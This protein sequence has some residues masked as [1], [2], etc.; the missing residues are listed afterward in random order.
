MSSSTNQHIPT[1]SSDLP[2]QHTTTAPHLDPNA[3][4]TNNGYAPNDNQL[5]GLVEAATAAADQ[6][7][8]QWAAAAAVAA[9][10]GAAGHHHQLDSYTDMDLSGN[11]FGDA[12]FGTG[13]SSGRHMRAPSH[14]D[15]P[16]SSGLTRTATKKR[17]RNEDHD[18]LDPALAGEG[19][20]DTQH[21]SHPAQQAP[22][23]YTGEEHQSHPAQQAPN[24]YTGE[25]IDIRPEQQQSLS[26][27]RAVG[28]HSAAALFRQPSSNKKYT[29]PPISK[30]YASLG[31]SPENF[32]HLQSAAKH[33]MLDEEHPERQDCVGQRGR[34]DSEMVKLRLWNCV[35]QFLDAEG[36]GARFFGEDAVNDG[37]GT[38]IHTWPRDQ[39]KIISLITPLLRRMV[40]NERQRRYAIETRKGGG[41]EA[42][43]RRKTEELSA[44]S[45]EFSP[46]QQHLQMQNQPSHRDDLSQSMA[47]PPPMQQSAMDSSQPVDLGLTDLL[48][49]GYT[50]DWEE[51]AR[52]Y[53]TYNENFE[54]DN[55]WSLSGLQQ[56]D[57]RG[58]VAA[59]DSHYHVVHN[60]NYDCPSIC[61]DANINRIVHADTTSDLQWRIGGGRN[62][63]A[64]V[65]FASSITRDV[66]RIIRE[67][68]AARHGLPAEA[69]DPHFH[70]PFTPLPE[71]TP[72]NTSNS[73][74]GQSQTSIRVNILQNGKRILPGFELPASQCSNID[75]VKQ[76]IL[77]RYPSQIPGLAEFQAVNA[78][79][80]EA[81]ESTIVD[82][83][84]VKVWLPD[85][86]LPVQS[87][88]DWAIAVLTTDAVDWM[89]GELKVLVEV[90]EGDGQ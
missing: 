84:K 60:G 14:T 29:R 67:N 83:W 21:Q 85:G 54:L 36:Y 7:V 38:R 63:P 81:R 57:W 79:T 27:A 24:D 12:N 13:M 61:E 34:G 9:A 2:P 51:I 87:Q 48:L 22:N 23:D 47:P 53:D 3:Q 11:G 30:L 43:R 17:K 89:D 59:V 72:A 77:R 42:R 6:D 86:V 8:S 33:Y 49:D 1:T 20:S 55:L 50:G 19:L 62:L 82:G 88:K 68:I 65:E 41:A 70:Q 78:A 71:S 80:Q 75:T 64:R 39:N 58:L 37:V 32:I 15:H 90:G 16:Q 4:L 46:E 5:A 74:H 52:C 73:S 18:N 31:I 76:A 44:N 66:S 40:T 25:E 45:P 10:A 56:P 26:D 69:P 35:R 28:I